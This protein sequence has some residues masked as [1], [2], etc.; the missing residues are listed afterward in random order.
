MN[1]PI[2]ANRFM[3]FIMLNLS[4][5]PYAIV[6]FLLIFTDFKLNP[7]ALLFIQPIIFFV[8]P[9]IIYMIVT[10]S[11]ITDIIPI[12]KLSI[13][14]II[15]IFFMSISIQPFMLVISAATSFF[16]NNDVSDTMTMLSDTPYW[17]MILAVGI[18]PAICEES[19][20]RGV[21]LTGYKK[22]GIW[23]SAVITGMFFGIMHMDLHQLFYATVTG[24]FFAY[25]VYYTNSI[26]STM[27]SHF[28]IN[29]TQITMLY[30]SR[31]VYG[32][33]ELIE[34]EQQL[35]LSDNLSTLGQ[36]ILIA[37]IF[38][39]IFIL[40]FREFIKTNKKTKFDFI[41]SLSENNV[42]VDISEIFNSEK[43]VKI[44]TPSFV[45]IIIVY[46]LF[47]ILIK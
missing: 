22:V 32:K 20:F 38:A 13:K 47:M 41:Y 44:I 28:I 27:L 40:L 43:K 30:F 34:M 42:N 2:R 15:L 12:K 10:K 18:L 39:P 19:I 16:A 17:I 8:I 24:I 36:S 21:I 31:L 3:L 45:M 23:K 4:I 29:S 26:F 9:M 6:L 7:V 25:L 11:R 5:S 1:S 35:T 14:N 46:L 33:E 37:V